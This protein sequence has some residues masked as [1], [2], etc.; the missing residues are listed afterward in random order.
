MYDIAPVF[1][2]ICIMNK[3]CTSYALSCHFLQYNSSPVLTVFSFL[4]FHL[5]LGWYY[6]IWQRK[7]QQ[8]SSQPPSASRHGHDTSSK[9]IYSITNGTIQ[10]ETIQTLPR[11]QKDGHTLNTLHYPDDL[12]A[13]AVGIISVPRRGRG[14]VPSCT[15]PS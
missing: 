7:N 8:P 2:S 4:I 11:Y 3:V 12:T 6:K 15:A 14:A 10:T 1:N 9:I 5:H 13:R